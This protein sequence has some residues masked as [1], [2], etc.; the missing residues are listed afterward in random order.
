MR[1][2]FDLT[3]RVCVTAIA[4]A[5]IAFAAQGAYETATADTALLDRSFSPPA[6][7]EYLRIRSV[8]DGL[9][10]EVPSGSRIVFGDAPNEAWCKQRL[11]EAAMMGAI[12]VVKNSDTADFRVS[13]VEVPISVAPGGMRLVVEPVR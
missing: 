7:T 11:A 3:I 12:H 4:L 1:R 5:T 8:R 2:L 10:A 9:A 13:C 6:R